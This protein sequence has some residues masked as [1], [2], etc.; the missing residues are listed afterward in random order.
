MLSAELITNAA[1]VLVTRQHY[2]TAYTTL[3]IISL[4]TC[5]QLLLPKKMTISDQIAQHRKLHE[6]WQPLGLELHH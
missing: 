1:F 6:I 3:Y 4:P 5:S 2:N